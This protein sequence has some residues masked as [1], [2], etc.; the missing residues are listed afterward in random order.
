M[1]VVVDQIFFP[2]N[3]FFHRQH[4]LLLLQIY[5]FC[6]CSKN[7]NG[8]KTKRKKIRIVEIKSSDY[9]ITVDYNIFKSFCRHIRLIWY[10]YTAVCPCAVAVAHTDTVI[11][12][13]SIGERLLWDQL[14]ST[15]DTWMFFSLSFV[16]FCFSIIISWAHSTAL[17][18]TTAK[19]V[20][21]FCTTGARFSVIKSKCSNFL[22]SAA[23]CRASQSDAY[24]I[25]IQSFIFLHYEFHHKLRTTR[26]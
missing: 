9:M 21:Y 23:Q 20:T 6:L 10:R 12:T 15:T 13:D 2:L 11:R 8:K 5:D 3:R 14:I 26:K 4:L 19:K 17:Y 25:P 24:F 22:H 16:L 18:R 1:T 7:K